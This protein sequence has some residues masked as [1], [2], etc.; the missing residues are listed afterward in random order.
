MPGEK[1]NHS[2]EEIKSEP[3]LQDPEY[4][5]QPKRKRKPPTSNNIQTD[6]SMEMD[7]ISSAYDDL[8]AKIVTSLIKNNFQKTV[9]ETTSTL[10]I[11]TVLSQ[12]ITESNVMNG[13]KLDSKIM[14]KIIAKALQQYSNHQLP[15]KEVNN[16]TNTAL[17]CDIKNSLDDNKNIEEKNNFK[18][19]K[20]RTGS[21]RKL[22][23]I[24]DDDS[25]KDI[26]SSEPIKN[27]IKNIIDEIL[28]PNNNNIF[29]KKKRQAAISAEK[30]IEDL[31]NLKDITYDSNID[32]KK[33]RRAA[34]SAEKSIEDLNNLADER[35]DYDD[36]NDEDYN[37]N[38]DDDNVDHMIEEN[39]VEPIKCTLTKDTLPT[40]STDDCA[41]PQPLRSKPK[42]G[43]KSKMIRTEEKEIVIEKK[44][45][46]DNVILIDDDDDNYVSNKIKPGNV[47]SSVWVAPTSKLLAKSSDHNGDV[48]NKIK[49]ESQDR[50]N[51]PLNPEILKNNNFIY[52]V[53]HIYKKRNPDL[54]DQS[55]KLAAE[56]SIKKV[57]DDIE[58]TN[59]P[60]YEG[61]LYDIALQ[62]TN[63]LL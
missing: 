60:F 61:P 52:I 7:S 11:S 44:E 1:K 50:S 29:M 48:S 13:P 16:I 17:N 58:K 55:A 54:D 28:L 18:S 62:V 34:I 33:K 14:S 43:P 56:Y 38:C 12:I 9:N 35:D 24:D 31:N 30:F 45:N 46:P 8:V 19:S 20:T 4:V 27:K 3:N 41:K 36:N 5:P 32:M 47:Q 49:T 53:A 6:D 25:D 40:T 51:I 59:K 42:A 26:N 37:P 2:V 10:R 22:K 23:I 21:K 57:L 15:T 63:Y 39:Y